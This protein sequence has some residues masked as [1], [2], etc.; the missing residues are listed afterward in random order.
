MN[1]ANVV[2]AVGAV[3]LLGDVRALARDPL[4]AQ[5]EGAGNDRAICSY[6]FLCLDDPDAV[7]DANGV[8]MLTFG[9]FDANDTLVRAQGFESVEAWCDYARH[10]PCLAETKSEQVG[11][12]LAGGNED[13]FWQLRAIV[14]LC[15]EFDNTLAAIESRPL[16]YRGDT[17]T[18][19]PPGIELTTGI[20]YLD[21]F[22][23]TVFWNPVASS[24][25]GG[26]S[27]WDRFPPLVAL[28]HELVHAYQR[29]A[30]DRRTYSSP[31]QIAAMKDENL[32]RYAF[33]RKV[34]GYAGIKPRPGNRGFYLGGAFQYLFDTVEWPDWPLDEVPLL[35]VFEQE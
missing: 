13:L 24:A 14:Y 35:D 2:L 34:P 29:I 31:L 8:A 1:L 33:Y 27:P 32:V 18:W 7:Y 26:A 12:Q 6:R 4:T 21:Q 3:C 23:A 28:A 5:A 20:N 22:T 11:W 17:R 30:E 15:S 10:D 16:V 19:G 25:Y 9:G